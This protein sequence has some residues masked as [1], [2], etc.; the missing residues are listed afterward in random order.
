MPIKFSIPEIKNK[1]LKAV[2]DVL[3]SG[4]LTRRYSI[5]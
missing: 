2:T 5:I 1:D 4:W 3:Q